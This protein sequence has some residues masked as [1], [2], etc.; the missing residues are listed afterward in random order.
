[1]SIRLP[2]VPRHGDRPDVE[3]AVAAS[4]PLPRDYMSDFSWTGLVVGSYDDARQVLERR[5]KLTQGPMGVEVEVEDTS[6]LAEV[7]RALTEEGIDCTV[8]DIVT[9]VYQG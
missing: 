9:Q 8:S 7:V 2:I 5:F 1:M 6:R 4:I 3:C